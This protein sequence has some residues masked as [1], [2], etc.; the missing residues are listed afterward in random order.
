MEVTSL[1]EKEIS[2]N[3]ISAKYS[4]PKLTITRHARK[5]NKIDNDLTIHKGRPHSR[6]EKEFVWID[7]Q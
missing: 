4:V 1:K 7:Y 6:H 3:Q 5:R 2:L